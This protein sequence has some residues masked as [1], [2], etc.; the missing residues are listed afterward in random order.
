M[1][2]VTVIVMIIVAKNTAIVRV[3][4]TSIVV[5]DDVAISAFASFADAVGIVVNIGVVVVVVVLVFV[6]VVVVVVVVV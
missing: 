4:I 3:M 6:G 1:F 2:D 5:F